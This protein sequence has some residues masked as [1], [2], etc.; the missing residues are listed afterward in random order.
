MSVLISCNDDENPILIEQDEITI[1]GTWSFIESTA[2]VISMP[3]GTEITIG[4]P[5]VSELNWTFSKDSLMV[6]SPDT[7]WIELYNYDTATMELQISDGSYD[8]EKLS[9][10]SLHLRFYSE[11]A[12]LEIEYY[13]YFQLVRERN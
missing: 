4:A 12:I 6:E 13:T 10:D 2:E 11:I 9:A 1:L 3:A 8:V 7:T 5:D